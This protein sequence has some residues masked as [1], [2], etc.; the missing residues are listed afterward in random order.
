MLESRRLK[1]IERQ[2]DLPMNHFFKVFAATAQ[3]VISA[4][5]GTDEKCQLNVPPDDEASGSCPVPDGM[6][7][8]EMENWVANRFSQLAVKNIGNAII[9]RLNVPTLTATYWLIPQ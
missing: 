6:S 2:K 9:V 7:P 5:Q 8:E 4:Y 1:V 3:D